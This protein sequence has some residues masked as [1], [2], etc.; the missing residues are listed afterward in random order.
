MGKAARKMKK[1][2]MQA[3]ETAVRQENAHWEALL[4]EQMAAGEYTTAIDT[5]AK[6]IQGNDIQPEFMYDAAYAY[7]M[8]GDYERAGQW[9]NN[10][11]SYAPDHLSVRILLAR[12]LMIEEREDDGLAVLEFVLDK[13]GDSLTAAQRKEIGETLTFLGDDARAK[14]RD[15]Y[16]HVAAFLRWDAPASETRDVSQILANLR[17]KVA[18]VGAA[19]GEAVEEAAAAV[20]PMAEAGMAAAEEAVAAAKPTFE[21]GAAA[22]AKK[23]AEILASLKERLAAV[24]QGKKAPT[25]VEDGGEPRTT[26]EEAHGT[27]EMPSCRESAAPHE[28]TAQKT[29]QVLSDTSA[30]EQ[31]K[32]DVLEKA[33]PAV[34]KAELLTAFAAG[35]YAQGALSAAELLL[36]AALDL[37]AADGILRNMA[38]VQQDLGR[39]EEALQT[40]ARMKLA[41]FALLRLLQQG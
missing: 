21:A 19:A 27:G 31:K 8:V 25:A 6:L 4:A 17:E 5:L 18:A 41:D 34:Q 7:F 35:Y 24:R 16:P 20:K 3:E 37:D 9:I 23:P 40:A 10:T 36:Q 30:A 26:A 11:L 32:Q 28:E 14:L 2:Q 13:G 38:L 1:K 12:L 15:A 22:V 39:R 29:V 33:L